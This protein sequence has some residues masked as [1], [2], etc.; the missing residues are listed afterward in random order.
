MGNLESGAG[1]LCKKV[2]EI[3]SDSESS[4]DTIQEVI[5]FYSRILSFCSDD[6]KSPVSRILQNSLGF[7]KH[8]L[9]NSACIA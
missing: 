6:I 9:F 4:V 3:L 5:H 2:A 8:S 7:F 1:M